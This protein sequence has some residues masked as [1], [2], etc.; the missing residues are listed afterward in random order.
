MLVTQYLKISKDA[1]TSKKLAFV[2]IKKNVG[3]FS[4]FHQNPHF[5]SLNVLKNLKSVITIL[6]HKISA[7]CRSLF[8][9]EEKTARLSGRQLYVDTLWFKVM[10]TPVSPEL[11]RTSYDVAV[12]LCCI[13]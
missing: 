12:S 7:K 13:L 2:S 10:R 5:R 8:C 6:Y 11:V 1:F 4:D 3:E 9:F